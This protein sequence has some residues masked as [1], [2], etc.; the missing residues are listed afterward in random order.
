MNPQK[1]IW[2]G[3]IGKERMPRALRSGFKP[4]TSFPFV[5]FPAQTFAKFIESGRTRV[6]F[7]GWISQHGAMGSISFNISWWI[8][9]APTDSLEHRKQTCMRSTKAGHITWL[10]YGD[11]PIGSLYSPIY[12]VVNRI[13]LRL[14]RITTGESTLKLIQHPS[15]SC[16]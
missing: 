4:F 6:I 15:A 9:V 2:F 3:L 1:K 16:G 7:S 14:L 11:S 12:W 5:F 10:V 8:V 13:K